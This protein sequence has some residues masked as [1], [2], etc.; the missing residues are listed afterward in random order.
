MAGTALVAACAVPTQGPRLTADTPATMGLTSPKTSTSPDLPPAIQPDWWLALGD[1]QLDRLMTDALAGN[2][3]LAL[4][5][6]RLAAA[7][8][9]LGEARAGLLPQIT[10]DASEQRQQFSNPFIY[11]SPLGGS[12]FWLGNAEV[13]LGWSLDLAGR[14]KALVRGA[15]ARANAAALDAAA[16]RVSLSGAVAQ[17]YV[18]FAGVEAQATLADELVANRREGWKLAQARVKNGLA[19]DLELRAAEGALASAEQLRAKG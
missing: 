4:A 5:Q 17:S 12:Y 6:A 15:G 11:P 7:R 13:D 14:Q 8:A 1:A 9:G 19:G 10:A 3:T 16:A 18:A 2:P